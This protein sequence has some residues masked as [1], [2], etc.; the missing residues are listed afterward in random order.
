MSVDEPTLESLGD[1]D[2]LVRFPQNDDTVVLHM[3]ADPAVVEQI[4]DDEQRVVEATAAYLIERQS[5]DDL[6]EQIDLDE[7]A[8]AYDG[9]IDDLHRQLAT[10]AS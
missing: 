7:V 9:Y 3:Y 5:A 8:A 4:A 1:H 6:P 10:P 2:Y